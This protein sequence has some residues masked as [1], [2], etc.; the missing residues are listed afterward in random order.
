MMMNL[1]AGM[2]RFRQR[3]GWGIGIGN[4]VRQLLRAVRFRSLAPSI[5]GPIAVVSVI[6]F[7]GLCF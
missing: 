1:K 3:R 2:L 6:L 5:L 4:G 7:Y